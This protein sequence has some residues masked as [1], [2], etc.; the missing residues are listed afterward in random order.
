M[1]K[2]IRKKNM[3]FG[4]PYKICKNCNGNGYVRII[5]YSETQTCKQCYGAGHFETEKKTTNQEPAIDNEFVFKLLDLIKEFIR[6]KKR[7]IH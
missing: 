3:K 6:G 5:P 1:K 7:T 4:D 2:R